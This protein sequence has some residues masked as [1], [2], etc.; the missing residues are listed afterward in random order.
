MTDAIDHAMNFLRIALG[1]GP[2]NSKGVRKRAEGAGLAWATV[3][4]A[5]ERLGVQSVRRSENGDGAGNG[6]GRC[7]KVLKL[8]HRKMLA[9]LYRKRLN[10]TPRKMLAASKMITCP[11][12][13]PCKALKPMSRKLL[14]RKVLKAM[15]GKALKRRRAPSATS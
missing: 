8:S 13:R 12:R 2:I 15:P 11:V 14:K 7:R 9:P 6:S 1:A 5:K 4:R 3:R 10:P